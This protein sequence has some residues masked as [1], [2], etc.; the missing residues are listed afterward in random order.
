MYLNLL[1]YGHLA[2]GPEAAAQVYFG[3]PAADLTLAEARCCGIRN[4]RIWSCSRTSSSPKHA[5]ELSWISW[6]GIDT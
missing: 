5:S 2:Y 6:S 1:N 3:K 4:S